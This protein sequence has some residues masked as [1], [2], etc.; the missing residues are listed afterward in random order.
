MIVQMLKYLTFD[1]QH[2]TEKYVGAGIV[3]LV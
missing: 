2:K 1:V 3:Q